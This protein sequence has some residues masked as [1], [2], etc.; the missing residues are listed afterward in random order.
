MAQINLSVPDGLRAWIDAQVAGGRYASPS[1]YLRDLIRRDQDHTETLARLR[2]ALDAG[3]AS[4]TSDR[5]LDDI[6]RARF[7]GRDAA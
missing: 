7:S 6:Y 3:R 4:G 2:A 1:D 5:T